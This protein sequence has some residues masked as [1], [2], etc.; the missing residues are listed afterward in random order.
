MLM[1]RLGIH[2][3]LNAIRLQVRLSIADLIT[4]VTHRLGDRSLTV[5]CTAVEYL[6]H[7][8]KPALG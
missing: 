4:V 3:D 2:L 7:V 5:T 8:K 1:G 6:G